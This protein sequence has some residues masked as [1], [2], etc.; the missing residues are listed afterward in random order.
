MS[1]SRSLALAGEMLDHPRELFACDDHPLH[2]LGVGAQ[3][4]EQ[5]GPDHPAESLRVEVAVGRLQLATGT[6]VRQR[7]PGTRQVAHELRLCVDDPT[8]DLA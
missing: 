4:H 7:S 3:L 5:A 8:A 2:P 6:T 1:C